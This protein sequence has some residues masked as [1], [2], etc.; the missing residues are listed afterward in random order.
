M[1]ITN[2]LLKLSQLTF[3][4]HLLYSRHGNIIWDPKMDDIIPFLGTLQLGRENYEKIMVLW[5]GKCCHRG[6]SPI[7]WERG[8]GCAGLGLEK[9][10]T[11]S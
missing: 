11:I 9:M 1:S 6:G 7:V 3:I 8:R 2:L 4:N 10:G 5:C